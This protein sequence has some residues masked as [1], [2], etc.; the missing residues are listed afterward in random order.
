MK[1]DGYRFWRDR[2][3]YMSTPPVKPTEIGHTVSQSRSLI[4]L[5]EAS[6]EHSISCI[7]DYKPYPQPRLDF[8]KKVCY[9]I[10]ENRIK[11]RNLWIF[12]ISL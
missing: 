3:K 11:G 6:G 9:N 2:I 1:K 8:I 10:L 5:T 12:V 4:P 7:I